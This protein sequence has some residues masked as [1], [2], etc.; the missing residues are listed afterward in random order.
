LVLLFKDQSSVYSTL[1][2][3]DTVKDMTSISNFYKSEIS[4]NIFSSNDIRT[5]FWKLV[6]ANQTTIS[7]NEQKHL[8]VFACMFDSLTGQ[9]LVVFDKK[10]N[11]WIFMGGHV[12]RGETSRKAMLREVKEELSIQINDNYEE[13]PFLVS[14]T[15]TSYSSGSCRKH[16]DIYYLVR[17]D[18][19]SVLSIKPAEE[20]LS[21]VR[22]VSLNEAHELV[23]DDPSSLGA[24]MKLV[25]ILT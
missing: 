12:D 10:I 8:V 17:L 20:E 23:K 25:E 2:F 11:K 14:A 19:T 4:E 9:V 22:W 21:E 3:P 5:E 18:P 1:F 24:V 15:N 7:D 13:K 16:L 6:D